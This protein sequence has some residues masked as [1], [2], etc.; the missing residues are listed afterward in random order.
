MLTVIVQAQ[1]VKIN[2]DSLSD[3][4]SWVDSKKWGDVTKDTVRRI[5]T[6]VNGKVYG[7]SLHGNVNITL[8]WAIDTGGS[9]KVFNQRIKDEQAALVKAAE[10][11]VL[12]LQQKYPNA[13]TT[14][15]PKA[16]VA[17]KSIPVSYETVVKPIL[18]P[19][20]VYNII[21]VHDGD[22]Y[23]AQGLSENI[24]IMG[25][26]C[27][28]VVSNIISENQEFGVEVSDS[29]REFIKGK[30]VILGLYDKDIYNR[31]LATVEVDGQD[32]ASYI[33]R[34]GW[35]WYMTSKL[36][37]SIRKGYQ[38]DRDY[39]KAHKLGLWVNPKAINPKDF[40][41]SHKK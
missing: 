9:V 12:Y 13:P 32:L 23:T 15:K 30:N 21:R 41:K 14:L 36:P 29:V 28:E 26:D 25:V 34:H 1:V 17:T 20:N 2:I 39:A 5:Y 6:K 4:L 8:E 27:P 10:E 38:K 24:R 22:T 40:R 35:G 3:N 16:Y 18:L 31:N 11:Q 33:L 19:A 37:V 7:D